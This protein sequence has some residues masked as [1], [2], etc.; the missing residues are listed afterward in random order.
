M[1]PAVLFYL[2]PE[3]TL[4][5]SWAAQVLKSKAQD[6]LTASFDALL[7]YTGVTL[8]LFAALT[9]GGVFLL[10]WRE[11]ELARP[12]RTLGYPLTPLVFL[13]CLRLYKQ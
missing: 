4:A 9:A 7:V 13:Y 12:Y 8:S 2:S 6:Q 5:A 1:N 11:P 3:K 10:R